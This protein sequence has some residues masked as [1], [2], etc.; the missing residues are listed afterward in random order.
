[1]IKL[2]VKS[3]KLYGV[4]FLRDICKDIGLRT[5]TIIEVVGISKTYKDRFTTILIEVNNLK[6]CI[7]DFCNYLS[8]DLGIVVDIDQSDM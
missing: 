6:G 8:K 1:M 2:K 7:F 5:N 4:D 3:K